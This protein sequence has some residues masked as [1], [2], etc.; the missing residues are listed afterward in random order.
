MREKHKQEM[1]FM[2]EKHEEEMKFLREKLDLQ[3]K[4]AG[5]DE[6]TPNENIEEK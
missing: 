1:T 5:K 2:K 3:R 4:I 6:E